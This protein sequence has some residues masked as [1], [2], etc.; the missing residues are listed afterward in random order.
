[1]Q[2]LIAFFSRLEAA[3][4]IISGSFVRP[5]VSDKRLR[6]HN[7]HFSLYPEI[8]AEAVG[9]GRFDVLFAITAEGKQL[10]MSYPVWLYSRSV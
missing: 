8:Q 9:G 1:M 6:L 4:D 2:Y 5:I 10:V 3:S 7:P